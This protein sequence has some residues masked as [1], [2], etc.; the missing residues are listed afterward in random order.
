MIASAGTRRGSRD[1]RNGATAVPRVPHQRPPG[2]R[3]A[4][5]GHPSGGCSRWV[6]WPPA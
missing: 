4:T 3:A 2:A 5:A 1:R 6:A